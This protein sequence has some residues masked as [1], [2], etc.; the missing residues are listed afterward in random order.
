MSFTKDQSVAF[1]FGLGASITIRIIGIVAI[2]D[3]IA[4]LSL[5][6]LLI[7]KNIFFDKKFRTVII[8]LLLW[9][10]STIV[11]DIYNNTD[12][13][14]ALKGFFTLVPFLACLIFSS[15]LLNKDYKLMIPFLWGYTIS[16]VLGAGLGLDQYFRERVAEVGFGG[17]AELEYYSKILTWIINAFITGAFSITYYKKYPRLVTF[18]ILIFSFVYLL[19]GSRS[20]FLINFLGAFFLIYFYYATS[21][22][23]ITL[24]FSNSKFRK[25]IYRFIAVAIITTF[26]AY[27]VYDFSVSRGYLGEEELEKY[28]YQKSSAIGI[29]S[30]RNETVSALLAIADAPILGHGS[31]AL[32]Y[33]GYGL[34]AAVLTGVPLDTYFNMVNSTDNNYIPSH[35]HLWQAWVNNGILGGIFWIYILFGVLLKF[36]RKYLF[37][38]PFYLAYI[39]STLLFLFWT[40]LFSPFQQKPFLATTLVFFMVLMSEADKKPQTKIA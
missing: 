13:M 21:K 10:A 26:V 4:V 14:D 11:S 36:I 6:Y 38:Y 32:D 1:C 27:S 9:M 29:L 3:I 23:N 39:I 7:Q 35:S 30:G 31:Y 17:V 19:Q 20:L 16:F 25:I 33:N 34:A 2:S 37:K 12:Y 22:F 15:W 18:I 28:E 24:S 5:P 8:L 40:I